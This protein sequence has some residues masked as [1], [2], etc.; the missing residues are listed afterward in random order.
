MKTQKLTFPEFILCFFSE[1]T[2]LIIFF[3]PFIFIRVVCYCHGLWVHWLILALCVCVCV[4]WGGGVSVI[5]ADGLI[6]ASCSSSAPL[7][8]TCAICPVLSDRLVFP[9][10]SWLCS[11]FPVPVLRLLWIP[12]QFSADFPNVP[13]R[14][15]VAQLRPCAAKSDCYSAHASFDSCFLSCLDSL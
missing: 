3:L 14:Y 4:C 7:F 1:I 5:A 15:T 12:F 13:G 8:K 9:L 11:S 2:V 6:S 10:C